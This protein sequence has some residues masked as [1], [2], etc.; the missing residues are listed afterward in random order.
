MAQQLLNGT[1]VHPAQNQ[2]RRKAMAQG[3]RRHPLL[4][5]CQL[6]GT[7]D[8]QVDHDV[9]DVMAPAPVGAFARTRRPIPLQILPHPGGWEKPKPRPALCRARILRRHRMWQMH[10]WHSFPPVL[11][12]QRPHPP[13]ML[14]DGLQQRFRQRQKP[15]F[16]TFAR[17]YASKS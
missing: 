13:H 12:K 16:I 11:V 10:A 4:D 6:T 9:M 15:V 5:A 8:L 17:A 14:T 1:D 2:M 3:V 7:G